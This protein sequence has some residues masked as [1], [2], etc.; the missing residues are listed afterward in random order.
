MTIRID[1]VMK[2][3]HPVDD[4]DV[5]YLVVNK[6][7]NIRD[8]IVELMKFPY[9][10]DTMNENQCRMNLRKFSD[11]AD[12]SYYNH[13]ADKKILLIDLQNDWKIIF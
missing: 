2:N 9:I 10:T 7:G 6:I 12:E 5:Y 11:I 1:N 3:P 8:G 4:S 13:G